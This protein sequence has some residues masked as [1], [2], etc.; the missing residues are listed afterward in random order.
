MCYKNLKLIIS[1]TLK[2]CLLQYVFL[3]KINV[4]FKAL[5]LEVLFWFCLAP[6]S[7]STANLML[8]RYGCQKSNRKTA[9]QLISVAESESEREQL[10]NNVNVCQF[11]QVG[12]NSTN[13]KRKLQ[14][15]RITHTALPRRVC[16]KIACC[17]GLFLLPFCYF[18]CWTSRITHSG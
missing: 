12:E 8:V 5:K 3:I 9:N 4:F 18:N 13:C 6:R 11:G 7:L 16:N 1:S 14:T 10:V 15:Q 2:R 17:S